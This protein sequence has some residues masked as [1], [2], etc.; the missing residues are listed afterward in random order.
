MPAEEL[1]MHQYWKGK[2]R[3]IFSMRSLI[4][5]GISVILRGQRMWTLRN[6]KS[7]AVFLF[8]WGP[9]PGVFP[10]FE[11]NVLL[12]SLLSSVSVLAHSFIINP[13]LLS[14]CSPTAP[15]LL[16]HPAPWFLLCYIN[17]NCWMNM[18][19]CSRHA[20]GDVRDAL[21]EEK[22]GLWRSKPHWGASVS[23]RC[24]AH[25]HSWGR[26]WGMCTLGHLCSRLDGHSG[27]QNSVCS[28]HLF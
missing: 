17:T 11:R 1:Y 2:L 12:H 15:L 10:R 9:T 28:R 5:P 16:S 13:L 27:G 7:P 21:G 24:T 18:F 14:I 25:V 20:W 4:F 8:R 22:K 26:C 19:L 23:G 6:W 3:W